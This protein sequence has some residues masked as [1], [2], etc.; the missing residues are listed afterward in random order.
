MNMGSSI[1]TAAV[2]VLT[3]S[4]L[5]ASPLT[6]GTVSVAQG[7]SA[8]PLSKVEQPGATSGYDALWALPTLYKAD[9]GFLNEIRIIG[10]YQGQYWDADSDAASESDYSNR[11][12]RLGLRASLMDKKL[13]FNTEVSSSD[14]FD[15]LY[16]EITEAWL[17]YKPSGNFTI[18][19][20]KFM[21]A[22]GY[23]YGISSREIITFE[24][25]Q[26]PNQMGIFFTPGVR[27][28]YVE[29][30]W[31]FALSGF[32]NNPDQEFG[33]L[34]GG[35]SVL[36]SVALDVSQQ[37]GMDKASLRLDYLNSSHEADDTRLNFFDHAISL[38]FSGKQGAMGL[39][40]DIMTGMG[41]KGDASMFMIMPT[42]DITEK[43]QAVVRFTY[44][45]GDEGALK[46]QR[47]YEGRAGSVAGDQYQSIYGGLNYYLYGH[48]LKTMLGAEYSSMDG[49]E[50]VLTLLAGLRLYF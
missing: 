41:D 28:T 4:L 13:T 39:N 47:R 16:N 12:A 19:A 15:P 36:P 43:L 17:E 26:L 48:R 22:F 11:R 45:T 37:L 29:G 6:A 34:D 10:R 7:K 5:A 44:S 18:R 46:P 35:F 1:P 31:T 32:S 50:D 3:A 42:Y 2:R 27:L 21:P 40:S 20:G 49:S 24:R 25:S 8:G 30:P 33:G 14:K 38:S 23:D 9:S